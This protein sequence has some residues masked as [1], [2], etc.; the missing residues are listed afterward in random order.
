MSKAAEERTALRAETVVANLKVYQVDCEVAALY[1]L[2]D[3]ELLVSF[4][5]VCPLGRIDRCTAETYACIHMRHCN[6]LS[7]RKRFV[8]SQRV[9][10]SYGDK[11]HAKA[12]RTL[13]NE[14][15]E[16]PAYP[17]HTY[18][19][20][21]QIH[22][23]YHVMTLGLSIYAAFITGQIRLALSLRGP[24]HFHKFKEVCF[25][26]LLEHY[27]YVREDVFIGPG[28]RADQHRNASWNVSGLPFPYNIGGR[29]PPTPIF[30]SHG[31]PYKVIS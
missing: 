4:K 27:R 26:Y 25:N 15:K 16:D 12:E 24:G 31:F 29:P 7:V 3:S 6:L 19:G 20:R 2:P 5:L 30:L 18:R 22:R 11:T 14:L 8:R 10:T 21:C 1:L 9:H 13:H 17:V 28:E 23:V